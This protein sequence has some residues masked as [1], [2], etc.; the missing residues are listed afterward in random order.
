MELMQSK[1]VSTK[2]DR[3]WF[4]QRYGMSDNISYKSAVIMI[5]INAGITFRPRKNDI[6]RT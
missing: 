5:T 2:D 6:C 3:I 4:G 1:G